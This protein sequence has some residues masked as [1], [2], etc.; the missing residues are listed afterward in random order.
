MITILIIALSCIII[1]YL[2]LQICK[3]L[4]IVEHKKR[5]EYYKRDPVANIQW[6]P[7]WITLIVCIYILW[8]SYFNSSY[9]AIYIVATALLV[10]ISWIDLFHPIPSWIRLLFQIVLFGGIV[11][12][13]WVSIDT[14]SL[15]WSSLDI[16]HRVWIIWSIIWFIVCTNAV[17]WFDGIQWQSSGITSIGAFSIRAVVIFIVFPTYTH[18]TPAIINQLTITQNIALS[19][20]LVSLIYTIIEYKP[21]GLIRD[22]GTTVYGFSLAYLALLWGAKVGTLMVTLSLVL[23]DR[24]WVIAYRLLIMRK[25]PLKWDY[26][27]LHHRLIANGRSRSEIRWFVWI[28]STIMTILMLLQWSN[29]LHK[30][31][32]L[33][34]MALLFFW[35]NIYLFIVKKLPV[36]MK[37]DFSTKDVEKLS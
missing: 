3:K 13:W 18:I 23:F 33:I 4:G 31:I 29:S 37:V 24:V 9:M 30:R 17:N 20:W 15:W 1:P 28:R 27:H 26:T 5:A 32:I 10:T 2:W 22:I 12:Y 8:P 6:L 35:V 19:L 7:L 14:I 21:R 34:M 25:N 36:E 16:S 11:L